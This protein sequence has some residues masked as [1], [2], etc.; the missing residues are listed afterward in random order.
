MNTIVFLITSLFI[1]LLQLAVLMVI[2]YI[3]TMLVGWPIKNFMRS[4]KNIIR[5]KEYL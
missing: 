3:A 5:Q 2:F 4:M 1:Y